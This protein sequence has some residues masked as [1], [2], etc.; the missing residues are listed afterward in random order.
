MSPS[1]YEGARNGQVK[2][3]I[4][5]SLEGPEDE[6]IIRK[7]KEIAARLRG[8]TSARRLGN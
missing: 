4:T 3:E 6:E 5:T 2:P 7:I 1:N 8:S